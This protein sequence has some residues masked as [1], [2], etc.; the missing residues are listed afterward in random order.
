MI[1]VPAV[2]IL[3]NGRAVRSK[4]PSQHTVENWAV[5]HRFFSENSANR[6]PLRINRVC[7]TNRFDFIDLLREL[8]RGDHASC[9][10]WKTGGFQ[11]LRDPG[12][13]RVNQAKFAA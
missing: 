12:V 9:R 6:E 1:I 10:Y 11:S 13:A 8:S 3:R 4:S 2:L 7:L 5:L